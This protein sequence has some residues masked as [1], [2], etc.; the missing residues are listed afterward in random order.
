MLRNA[1]I[2][3]K[4]KTSDFLFLSFQTED[5]KPPLFSLEHGEISWARKYKAHGQVPKYGIHGLRLVQ[6]VQFSACVKVIAT[7]LMEHIVE[8]LYSSLCINVCFLY[9]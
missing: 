2:N 7:N 4:N 1:Y 5:L 9:E 3:T 8:G 6:T